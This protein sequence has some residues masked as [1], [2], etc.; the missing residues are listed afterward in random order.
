MGTWYKIRYYIGHPIIRYYTRHPLVLLKNR[1]IMARLWWKK[2]SGKDVNFD[3]K[4]S[5]DVPIDVVMAAAEKDYG[6]LVHVIDSIREYVRHPLGTIFIISPKSEAIVALCREK[7]CVFIDENTVLPVT[8]KDIRYFVSGIDRSGW[9]FQQLLK[10]SGDVYATHEYF[11]ITDADTVFCR[12]QKFVDQG[13]VI[14]PASGQFC[15][16]PYLTTYRKLTGETVEAVVNFT[17]HH[18]L[19][20]KSKM[21]ALKRKIEAHCGT[22]WYRAIM[23]NIDVNEGSF[24][25]DYETYGQYV[26]ST[27]PDEC[28]LEHWRNVSLRRSQLDQL[29]ETTQKYYPRRKTISFHGYR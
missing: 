18:V 3:D 4:V 15:H 12:P 7:Q 16:I 5:S 6:V 22:E 9:L 8:K 27:Y 29:A 17:S 21:A 24:V 20:Q 23:D 26:Y 28:V 25:S 14:M 13:K 19:V 11:L 2:I 10:W 1:C